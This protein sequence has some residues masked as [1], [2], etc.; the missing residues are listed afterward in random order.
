MR[1]NM[2]IASTIMVIVC[3]ISTADGALIDF[4][5]VGPQGTLV[6]SLFVDGL[7]VNFNTES[8]SG[9]KTLPFIAEIGAPR[10][11]FQSLIG[12]ETPLNADRS[13]YTEGGRFNLTDGLRQTHDYL[14]DFSMPVNNLRLDLYDYRGDGPHVSAKLGVDNVELQVFNASGAQIGSDTFVL[15]TTRPIEG[16]VLHLGVNVGGIASARLHFNGIEGG[17]SIDNIA[18]EFIPEPTG[19]GLAGIGLL[20]LGLCRRKR[21]CR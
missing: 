14:I 1:Y 7:Q 17:T 16:N 6:D 4:E 19:W 9:N 11:G 2:I 21:R 20:G 5:G 13:E 10:V 3:A 12:E 18:F 8:P 15:P